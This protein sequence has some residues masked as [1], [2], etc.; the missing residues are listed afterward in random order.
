MKRLSIFLFALVATISMSAQENLLT[1]GGFE[2]YSTSMFGTQ[3]DE[4][5]VPFGSAVETSDVHGGQAALWVKEATQNTNNVSQELSL[6]FE[7]G[8]TYRLSIWYKVTTS[9]GGQDVKFNSLWTCGSEGDSSQD[10]DLLQ[11]EYFTSNEWKEAVVE[12]TCP[13]GATRFNFRVAVG[14]KAQVLFDDFSFVKLDREP[15]TEPY[16]EVTSAT[17]SA[18]ETTIN[19]A[20]DFAPLTLR[21]GNLTSPVLTE[22]TG[23]NSE[24]FTL[25]RTAISETE[26]TLLITYLP[27][28]A[29]KHTANLLIDNRNNPELSQMLRLS[30]SAIDPNAKPTITLTPL[31]VPL[32]TAKVGETSTFTIQVNSVNCIDYVNVAVAH[33][34][35]TGFNIN[36][37]LLPKNNS[38]NLIITFRPNV[39][40]DYAST[41]TFSTLGGTSVML[42]L[43]GKAT[44][45]ESTKPD[46][47]TEFVW[48]QSHPYALLNEKFDGV[49][50]NTPLALTDWQNVVLLGD[51]P[52]WGYDHKNATDAVVEKSAKATTYIYQHPNPTGE[53]AEMWL[54]TPALDYKNAGGKVFT[55]RVMGDFMFEGHDTQLELYYID[56]TTGLEL[57]QQKIEVEMPTSPD[58]NGEWIDFHVDLNGQNIADVFFFAFRYDGQIGEANAVTYYID[59]VSWGR[60]DLPV[61]TPDSLQIVMRAPLN[62]PISSG[63]I[64]VSAANLTEPISLSLAGPNAGKFA[65]YP[66]ELPATGGKFAVAFESDQLGVH[67]AYVRLSSRGAVDKYIPITV[68]CEE[69]TGVENP[70]FAHTVWANDGT[71]H[72]QLSSATNVAVYNITGKAVVQTT[73]TAG[74]HSLPLSTGMYIVRIGEQCT[75]VVM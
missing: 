40:G 26:E 16:L 39:A 5:G 69:T 64:T 60:T 45:G 22:I 37:T 3:F 57:Y 23:A 17:F 15:I 24:Y 31:T 27:T 61:I 14:K 29:G 67:E 74:T 66:E 11:G 13:K 73:F 18:V 71:L 34:Q 49:A 43:Q 52:W 59:D 9:A 25:K 72:L 33:T 53:R 70:S 68:L 62:T 75:K 47:T 41:L 21:Y 63:E 2:E 8:A 50:H 56:A 55:F 35:G 48:D 10:A 12:T 58:L 1:D 32:F 7:E 51:R 54:V 44:E 30:A 46:V 38:S 20:V 36:T 28:Q 19:T 6:T 4:W 42:N 65:L